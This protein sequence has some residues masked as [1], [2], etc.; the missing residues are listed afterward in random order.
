M[1]WVNKITIF[2]IQSSHLKSGAIFNGVEYPNV[3][4]QLVQLGHSMENASKQAA[5]SAFLPF[6]F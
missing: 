4:Y 2:S 6:S 1:A 3:S 5:F